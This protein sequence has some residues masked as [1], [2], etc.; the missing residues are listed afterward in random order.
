MSSQTEWSR[1]NG[2]SDEDAD[3]RDLRALGYEPKLHRA[4]GSYTSFALGFSMVSI[5]R[6]SSPRSRPG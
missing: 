6:G 2:A 5:T 3:S 4:V 1:S